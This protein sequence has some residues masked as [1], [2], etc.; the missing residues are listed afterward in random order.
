ML[1]FI[2][3]VP[4]SYIEKSSIYILC[5]YNVYIVDFFSLLPALKL[6]SKAATTEAEAIWSTSVMT[7]TA[8]LVNR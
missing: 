6:G 5:L 7:R 2:A 3:Q 4:S 1:I 8:F